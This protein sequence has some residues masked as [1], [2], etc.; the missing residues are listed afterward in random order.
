[1]NFNVN[2][3]QLIKYNIRFSTLDELL[4]HSFDESH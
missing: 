2:L 4:A 3:L 1:M